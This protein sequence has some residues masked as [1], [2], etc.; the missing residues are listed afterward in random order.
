MI[1]ANEKRIA[2]NSVYLYL[3]MFFSMAVSIYTSRVVLDTL[4]VQNYGIYNVV[5]GIVIIFSFLNGTMT[6]A[7]Q[8]FLN[9]EMGSGKAA[10]VR[11]TFS[12]A[13]V[14]HLGL[15]LLLLVVGETVG[16]WFVNHELVIAPA[17][18]YAANWTYQLSLLA[19]VATIVQVPFNALV[20]ANERMNVF[21][22]ISV[23]NTLLRLAVAVSV[24]WVVALDSLIVY[25]WL[26]LAVAVITMLCYVLYCR[27]HFTSVARLCGPDRTIA[28][29]MLRFSA[30]DIFGN[31]CYTVRYQGVLVILNKFGGTVLNAAG[32]LTMTVSGAVNQFGSAV[33]TSFRPQIMMKYA[34]GDYD[35]MNRLIVNCA[36]FSVLLMGVFCVPVIVCMDWILDVWLVDVPAYTATFCRLAL[37]AVCCDV[38]IM[39]VSAGIHATG[40]VLHMSVGSGLVYLAELPLAYW[41]MK[42]TG[43]PPAAYLCHVGI[44]LVVLT[45]YLAVMRRNLPEFTVGRF[46][47]RGAI[48]PWLIVGAVYAAASFTMFSSSFA[49]FVTVAVT[50]TTLLALLT[51]SVVLDAPLRHELLAALKRKL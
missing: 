50:S 18:M 11:D 47:W 27:R 2:R 13:L 34:A 23:L 16:L 41:L 15:A 26:M 5:G 22:V 24:A 39:T 6:G 1:S 46:V 44:V 19:A 12:S 21:A 25:A 10:R 32:G 49:A 51:W 8:R 30:S 38:V 31:L 45:V 36:R 28:G 7:T 29:A 3:R 14:I 35:Y 40:H 20:I 9:V 48:V 4:G 17:R 43:W 33:I 42:V 37:V